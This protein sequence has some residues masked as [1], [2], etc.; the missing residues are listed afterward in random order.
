MERSAMRKPDRMCETSV[1]EKT[2]GRMNCNVFVRLATASLF[3]GSVGF[4]QA[5]VPERATCASPKS[6][7]PHL[8]AAAPAE[9]NIRLASQ[10]PRIST[11]QV[12]VSTGHVATAN[13][14]PAIGVNSS[15]VKIR[16][17][18]SQSFK[19]THVHQFDKNNGGKGNFLNLEGIDGESADTHKDRAPDIQSWR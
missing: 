4:A 18:N 14:H 3:A 9:R 13:V 7:G 12:H 19:I 5:A 6:L 1:R 16:G 15:A 11:P 2:A 17:A 10:L 8:S